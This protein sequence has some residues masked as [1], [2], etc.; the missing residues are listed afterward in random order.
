MSQSYYK[1]EEISAP[2]RIISPRITMVYNMRGLPEA[3]RS[4]PCVCVSCLGPQKNNGF[5]CVFR[6]PATVVAAALLSSLNL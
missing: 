1:R 6:F 4:C 2:T 5:G 3:R